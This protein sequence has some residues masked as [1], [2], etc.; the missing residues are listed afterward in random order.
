MDYEKIVSEYNGGASSV[1]IAEAMGVPVHR[2]QYALKKSGVKMRSNRENSRRYFINHEFFNVIDSQDKAYW[3]GFLFADGHV[4]GGKVVCVSQKFPDSE[5]LTNLVTD[6]NSDYVV[7]MYTAKTAYGN[8]YYGRLLITSE[9]MYED[10]VSLGMVERKSLILSPPKLDPEMRRHFIRGYFDGDGSATKG[11]IKF[12][13]T[14]EMLEWISDE[15]GATRVYWSKRHDD[16]KNNHQ[17]EI[18]RKSDLITATNI[19]YDS[20][21]RFLQRKYDKLSKH[22]SRPSQ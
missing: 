14:S 5:H 20:S 12:C 19:M 13:G 7:K 10:L 4:Q 11:L 9:S 8:C 1:K 15:L 16:E 18:A 22:H 2:V 6:L 3:L 21:H 17:I